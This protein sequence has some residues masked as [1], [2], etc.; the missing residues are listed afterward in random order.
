MMKIQIKRL[1]KAGC[2][3]CN[4]NTV[5]PDFPTFVAGVNTGTMVK[6]GGITAIAFLKCNSPLSDETD[7][8]QWNAA[9]AAGDLVVRHDCFFRASMDVDENQ[10]D[11]GACVVPVVTSR[12]PVISFED[13]ADNSDYDVHALYRAFQANP[14][15]YLVAY[16]MCDGRVYGFKKALSVNVRES[17]GQTKNDPSQWTGEITFDMLIQPAPIAP[18]TGATIS[19]SAL[20]L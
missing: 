10:E 9:I 1:L 13:R 2:G 17:H 20:N 3:E 11:F 15:Q 6:N 18:A 19:L 12:R 7:V 16:F 14:S 8:T 5:V 4:T